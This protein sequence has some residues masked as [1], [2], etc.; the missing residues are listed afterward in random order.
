MRIG[1]I[2]YDYAPAIGG[3]GIV[4]RQYVERM[5]QMFPEHSIIVIAPGAAAED[6]VSWLARFR[7]RKTGGCPLFSLVLSFR[8]GSIIRK[9]RLDVLHVHAGSGGVFLLR[10]PHC[11]LVVTA[12]HTYRQEATYVFLHQPLKRLWK[13]LMGRLEQRTYRMAD[14]VVAV[15]QDTANALSEDYGIQKAKIQVI[16]NPV[17]IP[18]GD[19]SISKD[20]SSILYVGRLEERKGSWTILQAMDLLR[21]RFPSIMLTV[22]GSNLIGPAV[23]RFITE[24]NLGKHIQLLGFVDQ[25]RYESE[26]RRAGI[27]VVPSL[28]EG[29][30][31]VAAEAMADGA[32]VVASD[33]PGLRSLIKDKETGLLFGS[34]DSESCASAIEWALRN[35]L[36]AALI[37]QRAAADIRVRCDITERTK[38]LE[39]VM[40]G[41]II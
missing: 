23:E 34:G 15:S 29:F 24:K 3:M 14:A 5:R 18:A 25:E 8:L 38:D 27:V 22:V 19:S 28:L 40:R 35:S 31:L 36:E 39:G 41:A 11:P 30:G 17:T 16:E 1:I 6:R 20:Y 10:K 4:A 13:I 21:M 9:H 33:A 32:C 37:G 12:H 7:F 2:S 26:R